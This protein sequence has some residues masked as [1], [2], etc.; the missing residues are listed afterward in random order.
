MPI[1]ITVPPFASVVGL[2]GDG[3]AS[4]AGETLDI[5]NPGMANPLP[6]NALRVP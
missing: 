6:K 1:R 2:Q 4:T 3:M 5:R